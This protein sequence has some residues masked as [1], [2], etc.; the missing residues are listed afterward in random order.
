MNS[1]QTIITRQVRRFMAATSQT[2]VDIAHLIGLDQ[3]AVS[4]RLTGRSRWSVDDLDAL[5]DAGVPLSL[6]AYGLDSE[7]VGA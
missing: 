7:A 2:Q 6:S 3:T 5:M 4:R 1:S